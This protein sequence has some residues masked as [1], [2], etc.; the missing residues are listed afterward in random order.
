MIIGL[1]ASVMA[2]PPALLEVRAEFAAV[3]SFE[4]HFTQKVFS[5]IV[6]TPRSANSETPTFEGVLSFRRPHSLRWEYRKPHKRLIEIEGEKISVT[7][8]GA[9]EIMDSLGSISLQQSFSFLWGVPDEKNFHLKSIKAGE[10]EIRPKHEEG[11]PFKTMRV[12]IK[13]R[14]VERVVVRD[15][16]DGEAEL[17]FSSWRL[18]K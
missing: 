8:E 6:Q 10:F 15:P 17:L 3:K 4:V 2:L 16:L 1:F 12:I 5:E 7:E 18:Q 13:N 11:A 14:R 9:T